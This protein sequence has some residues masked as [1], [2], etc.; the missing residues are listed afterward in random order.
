[1]YKLGLKFPNN[2]ESIFRLI[3]GNKRGVFAFG[4]VLRDS[5]RI[6]ELQN[7]VNPLM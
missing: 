7:L 4:I 2:E 1:L 3:S 5:W 6:W